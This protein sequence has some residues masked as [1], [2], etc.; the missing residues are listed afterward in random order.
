MFRFALPA[1]LLLICTAAGAVEHGLGDD[2]DP[3]GPLGRNRFED[4]QAQLPPCA[5]MPEGG[6]TCVRVLACIGDSGLYFDGQARGENVGIILGRTSTGLQCSGHWS[7]EHADGRGY[8]RLKCAGGFR[9]YL[10][11]YDQDPQTGTTISAGSD[12]EGRTIRAW[13]GKNVLHFLAAG[14]DMPSLKCGNRMVPL[15]DTAQVK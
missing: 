12:S 14:E 5:H 2:F 4:L 8:A 3:D 9:F 11:F 15:R 6:Q 1:A 13:S 7:T 10:T